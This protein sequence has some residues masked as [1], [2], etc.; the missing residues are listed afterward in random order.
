[1]IILRQMLATLEQA[2]VMRIHE[3]LT[4]PVFSLLEKDA[5]FFAQGEIWHLQPQ[6]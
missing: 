6:P 2:I 5:A 3:G 4:F 1:M